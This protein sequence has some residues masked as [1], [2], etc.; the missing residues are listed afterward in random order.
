MGILIAVLGGALA[1]VNF[2][3]DEVVDPR[4]RTTTLRKDK[5]RLKKRLN[6]TTEGGVPV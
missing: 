6:T 4:L 2:A 5:K 3:I 1:L